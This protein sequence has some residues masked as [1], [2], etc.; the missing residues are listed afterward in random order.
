[1]DIENHMDDKQMSG[2]FKFTQEFEKVE[3]CTQN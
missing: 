3:I 1:M 2:E